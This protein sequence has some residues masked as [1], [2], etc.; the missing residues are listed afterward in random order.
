LQRLLNNGLT[1]DIS[2]C[3]FKTKATK[4]LGFIVEAGTGIQ[5]DPEKVKAIAEWKRPSTV[6]GVQSF[7]GFANYYQIFINSYT[8]IAKPLLDLTKKDTPFV[9]TQDCEAAFNALKQRFVEEP[10]LATYDP[11]RETQLEPDASGWA[12]GGVFTQYDLNL[13]T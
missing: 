9:W 6:R 12:L 13:Q 7:L 11:A 3:E 10:V 1:L 5:M 8:D 4:Y 2:K